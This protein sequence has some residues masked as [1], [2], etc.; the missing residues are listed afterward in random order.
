MRAAARSLGLDA[1]H[2]VTVHLTGQVPLSDEEFAT[3]AQD[4]HLLLGA[5]F[6]ALL[7]ILWLAVRSARVVTA[8]LVTTVVGLVMAAAIGLLAIRRLQLI[9]G[10]FTPLFVGL[11]VH[12]RLPFHRPTPAERLEP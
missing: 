7:G 10:A 3:L 9:P 12:F 5:M 1:A 8:I 11:G 2:G 4:A 6:A